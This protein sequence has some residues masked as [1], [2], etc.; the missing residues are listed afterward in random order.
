VNEQLAGGELHVASVSAYREYRPR[1]RRRLRR[2]LAPDFEAG[3]R[4]AQESQ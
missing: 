2:G 3:K 4:D 1:L